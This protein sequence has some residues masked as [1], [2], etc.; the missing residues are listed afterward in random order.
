LLLLV[1][2]VDALLVFAARRAEPSANSPADA[3]ALA[4]LGALPGPTDGADVAV[5]PSADSTLPSVSS[6]PTV[7]LPPPRLS[8]GVA[9][10]VK[11]ST[12]GVDEAVVRSYVETSP[13][14]YFLT[15]EEI[16]YLRAVGVSSETI[17]SMIR[18]G[19]EVREQ[20]ARAYAERER[21]ATSFTAAAPWA[22]PVHQPVAS[23]RVCG[24]APAGDAVAQRSASAAPSVRVI[25]VRRSPT[26]VYVPFYARY[27][28]YDD[29]GLGHGCYRS[30]LTPYPYLG[31]PIGYPGPQYVRFSFGHG[32]RFAYQRLHGYR[33]GF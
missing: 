2:V 29:Y 18:R 4:A 26:P 20:S 33:C 25:H 30:A 19:A 5:P 6:P 12:A 27:W 23:Q 3:T 28:A 9:D 24:A 11:L 31:Y 22:T 1:A 15:P 21:E 17:T 16:L 13:V 10:V 8:A 7:G 32:S 14:A